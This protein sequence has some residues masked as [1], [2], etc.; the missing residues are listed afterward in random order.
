MIKILLL[1]IGTTLSVAA[2]VISIFLNGLLGLFNLAAIPAAQL[3]A[4]KASEAA[5]SKLKQRN[6][7]RKSDF[8]KK[9]AK[10]ATKRLAAASGAAIPLVGVGAAIAATGAFVIEDY[11]NEMGELEADSA[12]LNGV[13]ESFN[14]KRCVTYSTD[15]ARSWLD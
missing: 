9:H 6:A 10:R 13:E 2:L 11:C 15:I 12:L 5:V 1:T 4:Y 3:S 7:V 14:F 8:H